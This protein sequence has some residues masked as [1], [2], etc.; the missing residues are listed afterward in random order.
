[1]TKY[2][3]TTRDA[4][5][6]GALMTEVKGRIILAVNAGTALA[7]LSALLITWPAHI[8]LASIAGP[9]IIGILAGMGAWYI[10][11]EKKNITKLAL[12][13]FADTGLSPAVIGSVIVDSRISAH[14][15]ISYKSQSNDI[16][17]SVDIIGK[18]TLAIIEGFKDDPSDVMRC[19]HVIKQCLDQSIKILNNLAV[20]E[21][22]IAENNSITMEDNEGTIEFARQGLKKIADALVEQHQ[23]NLDNNH[24]AL[25][26][27]V[28][29]SAHVI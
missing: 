24:N 26:I 16:Q 27:D 12:E 18:E 8:A 13:E 17:K 6:P 19:R 23:R 5:R 3:F 9:S 21:R 2:G 22:R 15:I 28:S 25:E 14:Y 29:V 10:Q 7:G 20:I 1:M 4:S 11:P